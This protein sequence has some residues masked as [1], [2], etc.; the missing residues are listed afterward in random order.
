MRFEIDT[1][2]FDR[3]DCLTKVRTGIDG[4]VINCLFEPEGSLTALDPPSI[5]RDHDRS[6]A[7]QVS[8]IIFFRR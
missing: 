8:A 6:I 1:H 2:G 5:D 3:V 7:L 4:Y